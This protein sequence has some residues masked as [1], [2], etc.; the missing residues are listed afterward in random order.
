[1]IRVAP[2]ADRL[3][4]LFH[5][6][7]ADSAGVPERPPVPPAAATH[8]KGAFACPHLHAA[9][10]HQGQ[11][12]KHGVAPGETLQVDTLDTCGL[13]ARTCARARRRHDES[14]L[15]SFQ[16][17]VRRRRIICPARMAALSARPAAGS[18][19]GSRMSS[20]IR[21][22]R[23]VATK[24]KETATSAISD[25]LASRSSRRLRHEAARRRTGTLT[26]QISTPPAGTWKKLPPRLARPR[27]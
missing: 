7:Q 27:T 11:A 22:S 6:L 5:I 2:A 10:P 8:P 1:M 26:L 12:R 17:G 25:S 18:Q 20:R 4:A 16:R 14:S 15:R 24:I 23:Q 21:G 9:A 13:R 19:R 3:R